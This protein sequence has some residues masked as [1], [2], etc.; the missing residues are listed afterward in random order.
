MPR[1]PQRPYVSEINTVQEFVARF[2]HMSC[3]SQS[4]ILSH[5]ML[6][7]PERTLDALKRIRRADT[8]INRTCVDS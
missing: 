5:L 8:L 6:I 3:C 1:G 7:Y 4:Q 2:N